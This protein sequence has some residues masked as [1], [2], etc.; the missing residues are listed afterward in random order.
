[1]EDA[2]AGLGWPARP[3]PSGGAGKFQF[4]WLPHELILTWTYSGVT[5]AEY[6]A[7]KVRK[8][9]EWNPLRSSRGEVIHVRCMIMHDTRER[10]GVTLI[11]LITL[12]I[13]I[14]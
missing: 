13:L 1:M 6:I 3:T 7:R 9:K 8:G 12:I 4:C 14:I 5:C 2:R 10:G 11:T